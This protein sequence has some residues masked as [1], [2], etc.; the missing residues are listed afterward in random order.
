MRALAGVCIVALA[1]CSGASEP[2][3]Q[4]RTPDIAAAEAVLSRHAGS[5]ASGPFAPQ[6]DCGVLKG[7]WEF[8]VKLADAV[9]ARDAD[10][11][12]ALAAPDILLDFGG[13]EGPDTLR[14]RLSDPEWNLWPAFEA[15]LPLG[16]ASDLSDGQTSFTLPWYFVQEPA[17]IDSY[18]AMLV[19]G[20]DVPLLSQP[21]VD[22]QV[23]TRLSWDVVSLDPAEFD[24]ELT[25]FA[26]VE[27][28]DG[29]SGWIAED[30]LRSWIDYRLIAERLE[31]GWQ[32]SV[33]VAGD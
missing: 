31:D 11:L 1:A 8:R 26:R 18:S 3:A 28:L 14:S 29:K 33:F 7:A 4:E 32:M 23:V 2:E 10:A 30:S 27:T 17:G 19:L 5:E 13:G 24:G 22:A 21:R 15:V 12:V 25:A 20:E 9:L 16:C 6:D